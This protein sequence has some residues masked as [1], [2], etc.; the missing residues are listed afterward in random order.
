[1]N[2]IKIIDNVL[3]KEV[4]EFVSEYIQQEPV[5]SLNMYD[6]KARHRIAG[7]VL[8]DTDQN[9]NTKIT[10]Q[11]LAG[12]VFNSILKKANLKLKVRRIH[13]GAKLPLQNDELHKD[14]FDENE[15]TILYYTAKEWKKEWGGYTVMFN[16]M[17][18]NDIMHTAVPEPGKATIFRG[19]IWHSGTPVSHFSDYPR[20]MLTIHCF[21]EKEINK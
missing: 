1:M 10:V 2:K 12:L 20:F 4:F 11:T 3:P 8:Y 15:V 16:D 6:K 19:S 7:R 14:S 9:I 18:S 17:H 21:L 13:L 5:W